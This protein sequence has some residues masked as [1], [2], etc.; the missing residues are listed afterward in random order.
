MG[1]DSR[2]NDVRPNTEIVVTRAMA[3]MQMT[4]LFFLFHVF[5]V[6]K[7]TLPFRFNPPQ[8]LKQA[9]DPSPHSLIPHPCIP[10][11]SIIMIHDPII[12]RSLLP[13]LRHTPQ[14]HC[15]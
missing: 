8:V 14:S 7:N 10:S 4:D 2:A 13:H 12:S 11:S 1:T 6:T 5:I 15:A 3:G 9:Q